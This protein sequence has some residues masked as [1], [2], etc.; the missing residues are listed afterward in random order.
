MTLRKSVSFFVLLAFV[1]TSMYSPVYGQMVDPMPHMPVPGVMIHLSPEYT[2]AYLKGITINPKNPLNFDFIVYKGDRELSQDQKK[3]E[4]NKLIKYFLASLTIP[5]DDQW[6]N[7]SPYEKDRIIKDDFGK[8]EM[9]RDLLAEDYILKQITASLIYPEENLGKT[10]WN[11]VYAQAQQQFGSTNIPVNTF[12]K[13]WIVPDDALV[14]EKGNTCYVISFHLKVMLE[15]DYLSLQ[16]HNGINHKDAINGVSTNNNI[17]AS[18]GANIVRQIVLP[19]LEKEINE[20]KNFATLRQVFSG[21]ILAAWFKRALKESLLGQMYA[22]KAKVKGVDQDPRTNDM[23]YQRYL[24]AYKKGVFN[25]IKEDVDRYSNEV[26]PRK[27]FSGGTEVMPRN[28][29][30][31]DIRPASFAQLADDLA[32]NSREL[33][34]ASAAM[35]TPE[36]NLSQGKTNAVANIDVIRGSF[37]HIGVWSPNNDFEMPRYA[38]LFFSKDGRIS[39]ERKNAFTEVLSLFELRDGTVITKQKNLPPPVLEAIKNYRP[40][41]AMTTVTLKEAQTFLSDIRFHYPG[42]LINSIPLE[43]TNSYEFGDIVR[44][45]L[46]NLQPAFESEDFAEPNLNKVDIVENVL[47]QSW[48]VY[49]N[50]ITSEIEIKNH[51]YENKP[52]SIEFG[53]IVTF[54]KD[55]IRFYVD[56]ENNEFG[57]VNKNGDVFGGAGFDLNDPKVKEGLEA[58]K[59]EIG[60]S[61]LSYE[62]KQTVLQVI[63]EKVNAAMTGSESQQRLRNIQENAKRKSEESYLN[64]EINRTRQFIIDMR[65]FNTEKEY[66]AREISKALGQIKNIVEP[67]ARQRPELYTDSNSRIVKMYTAILE[68]IKI[69]N[70][71]SPDVKRQAFSWPEYETALNRGLELLQESTSAA[72]TVE[73]AFQILNK[74][75]PIAFATGVV[76]GTGAWFTHLYNMSVEQKNYLKTNENYLLST[77]PVVVAK[78]INIQ[79]LNDEVLALES[80]KT[81][82]EYWNH[83][84]DIQGPDSINE[85]LNVAGNV[86]RQTESSYIDNLVPTNTINIAL[87]ANALGYTNSFGEVVIQPKNDPLEDFAIRFALRGPNIQVLNKIKSDPN[88]P[89]NNVAGRVLTD[90]GDDNARALDQIQQGV[91]GVVQGQVSF[92]EANKQLAENISISK[93]LENEQ[94]SSILSMSIAKLSYVHGLQQLGLSGDQLIEAV[95]IL[96]NQTDPLAPDSWEIRTFDGTSVAILGGIIE[97]PTEINTEPIGDQMSFFSKAFNDRLQRDPDFFEGFGIPKNAGPV[98][99][100]TINSPAAKKEISQQ[101][102]AAI[103]NLNTSLTAS[104]KPLDVIEPSALLKDNQSYDQQDSLGKAVLRIYFNSSN[105]NARSKL[106]RHFQ[107]PIEVIENWQESSGTY[108]YTLGIGTSVDVQK[109]TDNKTGEE[110]DYKRDQNGRM[111]LQNPVGEKFNP[112]MLNLKVLSARVLSLGALLA[113]MGVNSGCE[114][115]KPTAQDYINNL[116]DQT[117]TE[118]NAKIEEMNRATQAALNRG[119]NPLLPILPNRD[120]STNQL[121]QT[122]KAALTK[123]GIDFNTANFNLRIKRDRFGVALP[124]SQQ[125]MA[126]LAQVDGLVPVIL[127]IIPETASPLFA[128]LQAGK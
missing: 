128:E 88:D 98:N 6:V 61:E 50:K 47:T 37:K 7:L 3:I 44:R 43:I 122:D 85:Y 103:K 100:Q 76:V 115:S 13:V 101:V 109:L 18:I 83:Y 74:V 68:A 15:E 34:D 67:K 77:L 119:E 108:Y 97:F 5:D 113:L 95:E 41:A 79:S 11:K 38:D 54:H 48:L 62:I 10:F 86:S 59:K 25:Y 81:I 89:L 16:K 27:Y 26:I 52:V 36:E 33:D 14:Y 58:F 106:I 35:M 73:K 90:L 29:Y 104:T 69:I 57:A 82:D 51:I 4:Y 94:A 60:S 91:Q 114:T 120:L 40:S 127:K 75:L 80:P 123:G 46:D 111:I 121:K 118:M 124:V 102:V 117:T 64:S 93:I 12:N 84:G 99:A 28:F 30:E 72:M 96:L 1:T 9:G 42:T 24:K 107:I 87:A 19:Q 110:F 56:L 20:G 21:V 66:V 22:N 31:K 45:E 49:L 112:A 71:Q 92:E 63:N 23:I 78:T 70:E 105:S 17:T 2:P 8:T 65:G 53:K 55:D 116:E 125:D 126:Q 39:T 32:M